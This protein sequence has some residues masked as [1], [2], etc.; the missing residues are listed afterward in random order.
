VRR[1]DRIAQLV[2][3]PV[4]RVRWDEHEGLEAT[5]RGA[6]GLRAHR[7]QLTRGARQKRRAV[8][9]AAI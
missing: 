4:A 7:Q 6:G 5:A 2:V 9:G 1:G 3:A 8:G